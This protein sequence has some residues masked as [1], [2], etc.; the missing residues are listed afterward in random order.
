MADLGLPGSTCMEGRLASLRLGNCGTPATP[1]ELRRS[2]V[3]VRDA[4]RVELELFDLLSDI[5][6]PICALVLRLLEADCLRSFEGS[7]G[8]EVVS[9][10]DLCSP[11]PTTGLE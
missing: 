3:G 2:V 9:N 8:G 5:S 4:D 1:R 10:V 11:L 7:A 6:C